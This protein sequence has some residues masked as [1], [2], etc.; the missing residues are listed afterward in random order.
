MAG[1]SGPVEVPIGEC[2][3]PGTPH[4]SGDIVFLRPKPDLNMGLAAQEALRQS[5]SL[6]GDGLASVVSAITR[7]GVVAWNLRDADGN[8]V[9]IST[10][11]VIQRLGWS[12]EALAVAAKA[13]ELYLDTVLAPL[14]PARPEPAPSTHD[15]SLTSPSPASGRP[16]PTSRG[17]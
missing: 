11:G 13:R 9:P 4:P 8:S 12:P 6:R 1:E 5:G 3:C 16:T 2:Q 17:R 15:D 7:Y 10:D 14:V